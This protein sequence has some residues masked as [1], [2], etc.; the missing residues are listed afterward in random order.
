MHVGFWCGNLREKNDLEDL[1]VDEGIILKWIFKRW[2]E[3]MECLA[4]V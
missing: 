1:G 2:N 4:L 3:G